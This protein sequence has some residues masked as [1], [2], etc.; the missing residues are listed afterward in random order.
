MPLACPHEKGEDQIRGKIRA[1][2]R[3]G[4]AENDYDDPAPDES[5]D[6]V[7]FDNQQT[8]RL[9]SRP[10]IQLLIDLKINYYPLAYM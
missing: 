4:P 5:V 1:Q 2:A 7:C 3:P 10:N 9:I 6:E 8:Y